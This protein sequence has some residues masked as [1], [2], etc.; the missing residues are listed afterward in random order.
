MVLKKGVLKNWKNKT[1]WVLDLNKRFY[2]QHFFKNL[3]YQRQ[4]F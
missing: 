2:H 4:L 3:T 1:T